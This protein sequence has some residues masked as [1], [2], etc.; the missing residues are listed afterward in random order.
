M[1]FR[2]V[3]HFKICLLI[4][5]ERWVFLSWYTQF[6]SILTNKNAKGLA[7]YP[8]LVKHIKGDFNPDSS[9]NIEYYLGT[10][11][12]LKWYA[13]RFFKKY[14]LIKIA[15]VYK[16][17]FESWQK[18]F[19]LKKSTDMSVDG[20]RQAVHFAEDSHEVTLLIWE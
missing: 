17:V 8:A 10:Y 1:F 12:A 6:L 16:T 20:N 18:A 4:P 2:D 5:S 13:W 14:G 15:E 3:D 11:A 19:E 7:A 9:W